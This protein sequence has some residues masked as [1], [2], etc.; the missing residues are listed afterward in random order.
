MLKKSAKIL[1]RSSAHL[2][3]AVLV[4]LF[5]LWLTLVFLAA[6]ASGSRWLL[7]KI[8][9]SQKL[10][11]FEVVSGSLRDGLVVCRLLLHC[12]FVRHQPLLS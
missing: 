7:E 1:W 9:Q 5:S 6:S 12:Y 11:R 8:V 2:T 4:L 3:V 10:V